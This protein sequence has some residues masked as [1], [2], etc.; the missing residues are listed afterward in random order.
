[1]VCCN[2]P[3]RFG[4]HRK[5]S[6]NHREQNFSSRPKGNLRSSRMSKNFEICGTR[7]KQISMYIVGGT[8]V[9]SV[10]KYPW[11]ASIA[12]V[13]DDSYLTDQDDNST[14]ILHYCGASILT[15]RFLISSA[16][17]FPINNVDDLD[18]DNYRIG[19]GNVELPKMNIHQIEHVF[20]HPNASTDNHYYDIAI[21]K[22][23]DKLNF[24]SR[25]RPI[26][27]PFLEFDL[28]G[29]TNDDKREDE[30]SNK[31]KEPERNNL[32]MYGFPNPN[33]QAPPFYGFPNPNYQPP[34]S[35][36]FNEPNYN[37]N[38]RSIRRQ[39][40]YRYSNRYS[41]NIYQFRTKRSSAIKFEQDDLY[42]ELFTKPSTKVIVC[43]LGD[44]SFMGT[45]SPVLK[46]ADLMIVDKNQCNELYKK[47]NSPSLKF[48]LNEEFICA[49]DRRLANKLNS[50]R[51]L[52]DPR[53]KPR[54]NRPKR[55]IS[56]WIDYFS[57]RL[58]QNRTT[59]L[60]RKGSI[61]SDD[62]RADKIDK[63][64]VK[65]NVSSHRPAAKSSDRLV[66]EIEL[67]DSSDKKKKDEDHNEDLVNVLTEE[68]LKE[69]LAF[70]DS[71]QGDSGGGLFMPLDAHFLNKT[72]SEHN[73]LLND[74]FK[75][76]FDTMTNMYEKLDRKGLEGKYMLIG[77]V[78]LGRDCG[79]KEYPGTKLRIETI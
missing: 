24:N 35:Q 69:K 72:M 5:L 10:T 74:K 65:Q 36:N 37:Y 15:D 70:S 31:Y 26:C 68:E 58:K 14:G 12:L 3:E 59:K 34:P 23:K 16:H 53:T 64:M 73:P 51:S 2:T 41:N 25:I 52:I 21:I 66:G 29:E 1:M 79:N 55:S 48:G 4:A 40:P 67:K 38:L 19:V 11:Y 49:A 75:K 28:N 54:S 56:Y 71:C 9:R 57:N 60:K 62:D 45:R 33:Y 47:L 42:N 46:E 18:L 43:G 13:K 76:N 22:L 63:Q 27:L 20:I 44:T 77:I 17:C 7:S 39:F 30:N 61:R 6:F 78:S 32:Q 50:K 8:N